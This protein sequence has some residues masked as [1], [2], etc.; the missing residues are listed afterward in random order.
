MKVWKV[1]HANVINLEDLG[2]SQVR[3]DCV[4]IKMLS[5][6]LT[7]TEKLAYQGKLKDCEL[8][9]VIGRNG[10]GMISEVDE[11]VTNFKRGD[12]VYVSSE[13]PCGE[14][15]FCKSERSHLCG[16]T[17]TYGKDVDGLMSDFAIVNTDSLYL[18]PDRVSVEEAVFIEKI[19]LAINTINALNVSRGDHLVI[20][21]A[22]VFGLI[23]AQVALYYQA[24]PILVDKRAERLALAEERDIYYCI[25]SAKED[26]YRRVVA[27][28]GGKM[29]SRVAFDLD[30]KSVDF[31]EVL[32]LV[33]KGGKIAFA[34]IDAETEK[35][36]IDAKVALDKNASIFGISKTNENISS[37]IN[38]LVNK[39][40]NVSTLMQIIS[41]EEVGEYVEKLSK[42]SDFLQLVV[43]L[44]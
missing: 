4:K 7:S 37:A 22:S 20:L 34:G 24:V 17:Q 36:E 9:I 31:N 44:K 6:A 33:A 43:K 42:N 8:P 11:S 40:V 28:S 3:K 35:I 32:P 29:A 2:P 1:S 41:F 38:M 15:Y 18:L 13:V 39:Q 19:A 5:T 23:L 10:A 16:Y 26:V 27:I 21:G 14:C 25:N 30:G 12:R